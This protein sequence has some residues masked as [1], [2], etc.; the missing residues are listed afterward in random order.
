M[1]PRIACSATRR[2][3]PTRPSSTRSR[4]AQRRDRP[5]SKKRLSACGGPAEAG[6]PPRTHHVVARSA[7]ARAPLEATAPAHA[8]PPDPPQA[9]QAHR[10]AEGNEGE[11][12]SWMD[13]GEFRVY[14]VGLLLTIGFM[15]S[16]LEP[17]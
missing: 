15:P 11:S 10:G 4:T 7:C 5:R 6:L 9:Q 3:S 17:L 8:L 13:H 2:H 12:D 1:S 16:P 14:S